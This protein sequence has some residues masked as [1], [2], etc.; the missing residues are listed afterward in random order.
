LEHF[1][2]GQFDVVHYAGHA[3]FD[4]TAP[5]RSGLICAPPDDRNPAVLSGAD[6]A[7][8]GQLPMLVFFNACESAR[9]RGVKKIGAN[10]KHPDRVRGLVSVAEAFMRGGVANFLGTYWPVGD[11]AASKFAWT[12]YH[13]LLDGQPLGLAVTQAR[14]Q[15]LEIRSA[16]WADYIHYG[17]PNFVLKTRNIES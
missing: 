11:E 3:F 17:S 2:S 9:I 4:P 6:L 8:L 15:V 5:E 1:R 13:S 14:K 7:G 10:P 12:L 16:D